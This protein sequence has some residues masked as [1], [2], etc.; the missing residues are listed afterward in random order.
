[1]PAWAKQTSSRSST[2]R[3]PG[4]RSASPSA[5]CW[6]R[7]S[8]ATSNPWKMTRRLL[9]V[10]WRTGSSPERRRPAK[11]PVSQASAVSNREVST[12]RTLAGAVARLEVPDRATVD[13]YAAAGVDRLI[14]RPRPEMDASALERFAADAGRAL[15]L[16][17]SRPTS[18]PSRGR[19]RSD[20]QAGCSKIT[21]T[22][23]PPPPPASART[24]CPCRGTWSRRA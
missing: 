21:P 4:A 16:K 14:L 3:T 11:C 20:S 22:P 1:M 7:S 19:I 15:G 10:R 6:R 9:P 13:A 18:A 8:S 12:T 23:S 5:P 24:A 2:P 17:P